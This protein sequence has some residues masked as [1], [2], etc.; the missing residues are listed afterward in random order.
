MGR[1]SYKSL[2]PFRGDPCEPPSWG[3]ELALGL[4]RGAGS[5]LDPLPGLKGE[6][7]T[8]VFLPSSLGFSEKTAD[9]L[10][11]WQCEP[12][13]ELVLMGLRSVPFELHYGHLFGL[14]C[15]SLMKFHNL[16]FKNFGI[17]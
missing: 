11:P 16:S 3:Q 10:T 5:R 7:S 17:T 8:R 2:S 4:A 9:T 12:C 6:P 1:S 13:R 14:I 15:H